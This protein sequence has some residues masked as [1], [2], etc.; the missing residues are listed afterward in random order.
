MRS[1]VFVS[2]Q[3]NAGKTTMI[4]GLSRLLS[5]KG[6]KIG[7]M[8]PFGER[9]VYKKKRLWDYDS[10]A[11]TRI[12]GLKDNPE[13]LSIGF[14]HSKLLYMYDRSGIEE[15]VKECFGRVSEGKDYVFI[16]GS[17][18]PRY[19][20]SVYLDPLSVAEY[21]NSKIVFVASG[22]DDFEIIDDIYHMKESVKGF[23]ERL[24]GVIINRV[25]SMDNWKDVYLPL[26][27]KKG[28]KVLGMIPRV[29][30]LEIATPQIIAEQLFAKVISGEEWLSKNKIE[31]VFIGA[32]S[33]SAAVK[34]PIFNKENKLIITSGDRTDLIVASLEHG[35]SCILLT[36]NIIPP[37]N[38][39]EKAN[40]HQVPLL[41]VPWD[42]YTAAK[43]VENI[44]ILLNEKDL[45]KL[46]LT[47]KLIK[48]NVD[49]SFLEVE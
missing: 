22:T 45:E 47:E 2:N 26:L 35:T 28:V 23:D 14:D 31:D 1:F 8:K 33:A 11:M 4:I 13:D 3:N 19:G 40:K 34:S 10:A 30:E 48:E 43:H 39:I 17:K 15:K 49:V 6:K 29:K 42:T 24:V 36:N 25:K 44:R 7:Y 21:T 41:L 9:V 37:P 18:N 20:C 16:E 5:G 27:E 12:F 46:E 38:I 32:M